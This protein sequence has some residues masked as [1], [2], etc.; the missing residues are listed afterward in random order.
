AQRERRRDELARL[1]ADD[2]P[3]VG[4]AARRTALVAMGGLWTVAP[5]LADVIDPAALPRTLRYLMPAGLLVLALAVWYRA[6]ASLAKTAINRRFLVALLAGFCAHMVHLLT[7][8]IAALPPRSELA[9]G[10]VSFGAIG[11]V[12]AHTAE[13]RLWPIVPLYWVGAV[14]AAGLRDH[15]ALVLSF[16]NL[17][18]TLFVLT[19]W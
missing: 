13:R 10:M 14:A 9:M 6:R 1:E 18:L 5:L 3:G 2:D 12:L 17:L 11:A 19:I 8:Q 16:C 4:R 7:V 15:S